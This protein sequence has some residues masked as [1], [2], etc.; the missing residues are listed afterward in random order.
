MGGPTGATEALAI[1]LVLALLGAGCAA[2]HLAEDAARTPTTGTSLNVGIAE[3]VNSLNPVT[4]VDGEENNFGHF[5][6]AG[7]LGVN[8]SGG[9]FSMLATK[10]PSPSNGLISPSGR[11][12]TFTLRPDLK[13]SDGRPITTRDVIFGW[14]IAMKVW[15]RSMSRDLLG[16]PF[17]DFRGTQPGNIPFDPALRPATL[18]PPARLAISPNMAWQLDSDLSLSVPD[19][20]QLSWTWIRRGWTLQS[21]VSDPFHSDIRT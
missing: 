16:H 15:G 4:M 18:R 5:V 14:H 19:Q 8:G 3:P 20:H 13:W 9:L 12:I 17:R 1:A 2:D 10:V 7:L 21:A 6:W 11:D